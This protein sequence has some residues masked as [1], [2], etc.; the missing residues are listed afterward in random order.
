MHGG[1]ESVRR[2]GTEQSVSTVVEPI[3]AAYAAKGCGSLPL[4]V[5]HEEGAFSHRGVS[6]D[7]RLIPGAGR[8][9]SAL[10]DGSIQLAHVA[11]PPVLRGL[12]SGDLQAKFLTGGVRQ[13][14]HRLLGAP[15]VQVDGAEGLLDLTVGV[16][17]SGVAGLPDVDEYLLRIIAS[18]LGISANFATVPAPSPHEDAVQGL[19]EGQYDALLLVPPYAL[20][21]QSQGGSCLV[22]ASALSIPFQLGGLVARDDWLSAHPDSARAVVLAYEQGIRALHEKPEVAMTVLEKYTGIRDQEL[23]ASTYEAFARL[24]ELPAAPSEEGLME[25]LQLVSSGTHPR[26]G[27]ASADARADLTI[28]SMVVARSRI[29]LSGDY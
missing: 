26:A 10:V 1:L 5:A 4:W 18:R 2:V 29:G 15:G 16:R 28:S 14:P 17:Q 12:A 9:V 21:A 22:D 23:L 8:A 3:P 6:L 24:F 19:L 27:M 25:A 13:V 20:Y 11:S 7:L